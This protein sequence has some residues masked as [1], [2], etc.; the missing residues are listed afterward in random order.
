MAG[1]A[2][3]HLNLVGQLQRSLREWCCCFNENEEGYVTA[4]V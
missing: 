2:G 1:T 4:G 3:V